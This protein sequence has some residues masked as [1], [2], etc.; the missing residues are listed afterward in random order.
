MRAIAPRLPLPHLRA[1]AGIARASWTA[2]DVLASLVLHKD[3]AAGDPRLLIMNEQFLARFDFLGG[4]V[5]IE[6]IGKEDRR[7]RFAL[8][9][10]S[11]RVRRARAPIVASPR[12]VSI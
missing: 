8:R 2:R 12:S 5:L 7:H 10:G 3:V 11:A 6:G 9:A 1:A 4:G